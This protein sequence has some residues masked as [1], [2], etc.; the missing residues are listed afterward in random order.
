MI[1]AQADNHIY[2]IGAG[3][4]YDTA[5]DFIL[6]RFLNSKKFE[7]E[8]GQSKTDFLKDFFEEYNFDL[9]DYFEDMVVE[10]YDG[11]YIDD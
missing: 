3:G 4:D 1:K 6:D 10:C 8:I 7:H 5:T 9:N 11:D 2:T